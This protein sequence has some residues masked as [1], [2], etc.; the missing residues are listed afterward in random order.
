MNRH[1]NSS[2]PSISTANNYISYPGPYVSFNTYF[3]KGRDEKNNYNKM[4]LIMDMFRNSLMNNKQRFISPPS[5]LWH[6][7]K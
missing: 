4:Q 7:G 2:K 5:R 6:S 3:H 1:N